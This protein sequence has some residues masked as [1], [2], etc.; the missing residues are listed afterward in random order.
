[1]QIAVILRVDVMKTQ[2]VTNL[3]AQVAS[4]A[5]YTSIRE[6]ASSH[7][8]DGLQ[9]SCKGFLVFGLCGLKLCLNRCT[10]FLRTRIFPQH[11][12]RETERQA[13]KN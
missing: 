10:D 2:Q 12:V 5:Q 1:M 4:N 11:S 8:V 6:N 3:K 13:R 9:V 7:L